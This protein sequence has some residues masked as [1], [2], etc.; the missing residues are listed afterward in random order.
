MRQL[1]PKERQG[2]HLRRVN[3]CGITLLI[4]HGKA[5]RNSCHYATRWFTLFFL[6]IVPLGRYYVR[7]VGTMSYQI[8]AS[9]PLSTREI[10]WTYLLYWIVFPV[11]IGIL[12]VVVIAVIR[13]LHV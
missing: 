2:L 7:K 6:P 4:D 3:G 1:T 13:Y 11:V 12:I 10:I 8:F 5:D 9:M